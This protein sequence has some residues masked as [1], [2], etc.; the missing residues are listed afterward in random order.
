MINNPVSDEY[1]CNLQE[2]LLCESF[3]SSD[4]ETS[5]ETQARQ[6]ATRGV[7]KV[8]G[9]KPLRVT[10]DEGEEMGETDARREA[11]KGAAMNTR[12]RL[13]MMHADKA[14]RRKSMERHESENPFARGWRIAKGQADNTFNR[15]MAKHNEKAAADKKSAAD[16]R[17]SKSETERSARLES[18]KGPSKVSGFKRAMHPDAGKIPEPTK[19][20]VKPTGSERVGY[21]PENKMPTQQPHTSRVL[22]KYG[23]GGGTS[24]RKFARRP[25]PDANKF[26]SANNLGSKRF[27]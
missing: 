12:S 22:D 7:K 11:E 23:A 4:N 24:T 15:N 21:E 25:L 3:G 26:G 6:E 8:R 16:E 10:D 1:V 13:K 27:A 2:S 19:R 14:T 9:A 20:E 5:E 18:E 17:F